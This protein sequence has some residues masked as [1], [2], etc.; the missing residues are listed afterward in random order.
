MMRSIRFAVVAIA[1]IGLTRWQ[2]AEPFFLVGY[3]MYPT[4]R[5]HEYLI[6]DKVGARL[7]GYERGDVVLL[8]EPGTGVRGLKRIVG[9]PGERVRVAPRGLAVWANGHFV[10]RTPPLP[11]TARA[12]FHGVRYRHVDLGPDEYFV[13]G[14]HWS[15]SL[16]SRHFGP[17]RRDALLGTAWLRVLPR[18]AL[19]PG[20]PSPLPFGSDGGVRTVRQKGAGAQGRG[21]MR[22]ELGMRVGDLAQRGSD[23]AGHVDASSL[24]GRSGNAHVPR[25]PEGATELAFERRDLLAHAFGT[26]EVT[27]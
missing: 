6:V 23:G 10:W 2:L 7:N 12:A 16:D 9:L 5:P 14:D 11:L 19:R 15:V 27:Q 21:E 8:A 20:A 3:S 1:L 13:L 26:A 25:Q 17:V 18:P 4:F 22:T 24:A